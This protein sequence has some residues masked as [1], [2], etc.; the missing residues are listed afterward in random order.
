MNCK[1]TLIL[2]I[3]DYRR[4]NTYVVYVVLS[5]ISVVP[6]WKPIELWIWVHFQTWSLCFEQTIRCRLR[7]RCRRRSENCFRGR[8][9][10]C[11]WSGTSAGMCD[12]SVDCSWSD[13]E[14]GWTTFPY[15]VDELF[16]WQGRAVA[17]LGEWLKKGN[18]VWSW[19]L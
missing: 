3:Q 8:P 15:K 18:H 19:L 13:Q 7:F 14:F 10:I 2:I 17:A 12:N 6:Q 16:S 11:H 5:L 4:N 9:S 1:S